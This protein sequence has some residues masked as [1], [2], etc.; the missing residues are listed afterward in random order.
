MKT[1]IKII[2]SIIK[3]AK[4]LKKSIVFPELDDRILKAASILSKEEIVKPILIGK[5]E[6]IEKK[7][8]ELKISIEG[9]KIIEPDDR[10]SKDIFDNRKGKITLEDSIIL[11]KQPNYYGACLVHNSEAD[12]MVCGAIYASADTFRPAL[13]IIKTKDHT[14]ASTYFL[15]V[16]DDKLYLFADCAL[17]IN[18]SDIQLA[19]IA[20][21]TANSSKKYGIEPRVAML[22]F[23][24]NGSATHELSQKVKN[25]TDI[26]KEREPELVVEGEIQLDVAM[27]KEVAEHKFKDSK[28]KGDANIF[29]FPDL[30]SANIGYKLVERFGGYMAIGPISQGFNKP[31][32]DL[33][34]GCSVEDIVVVAAITAVQSK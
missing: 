11:S 2:D 15:M 7:A 30:N 31:V 8:K 17:N 14:T 23:S 10:F 26:V 13:Q 9:I 19:E 32:N 1:G 5:K 28:I 16:K 6:E 12:G 34:R 21:S 3:E 4:E 18:P 20:I 27:I 22:S 25:A 33:S 29:I 24:T